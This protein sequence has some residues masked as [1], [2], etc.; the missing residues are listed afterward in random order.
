MASELELQVRERLDSGAVGDAAALAIRGLGPSVLRFLQYL[1]HNEA[2]A[3]DAFSEFA[4]RLWR[5][6]P[7]FRGEGSLRG[8]AFR[9]ASRC[10]FDVKGDAW[11]RRA[12]RLLT[13]EV[14]QLVDEVRSRTFERVERART[15]LDALRDELPVTDQALLALRIDQGLSWSEVAQVLSGE[16]TAVTPDAAEKR[17]ERLKGRLQKMARAR[18]LLA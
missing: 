4:E 9:M 3:L 1:L 6:L 13:R 14:S 15:A 17:F 12:Q 5:G 18:G 2:D 10:A 11:H 8:F 7:D 16:G